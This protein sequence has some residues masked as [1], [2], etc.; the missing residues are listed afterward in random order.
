[1]AA[2]TTA[3]EEETRPE[4]TPEP[5]APDRVRSIGARLL[6][7]FDRLAT[8]SVLACAAPILMAAIL[9]WTNRWV[10]D[11]GWINMRVVEQFLAGNGPVYN[12]GER[13][14]V[15][16]STLWFWILLAGALV[17]PW[18]EAQITGA[19]AG[20]LLTLG[21]LIFASF[22]A[23][24]LFK[25]RKP[26]IYVPVGTLAMAA[27]PPFWDFTTSGLETG[28]SFGWLGCCFWMLARR[29]VAYEQGIRR[30]AWWPVFPALVIGLGPLVRPDFALYSGLFAIA[31]LMSSRFRWWDWPMC[32]V[33]ALAVPAGYQI[34]RMGFYASMVPNTA[35]AKD[36]T[37]SH[38][39]QGL[40]YLIDYAG[41]YV[42]VVPLL[43]VALGVGLHVRT[44]WCLR[45]W[46][47]WAVVGAPVLG[48]LLHAL[49]VVRIGGDFMHARF[50]LPD[51]F[52]MMMPV[53]VVG[54]TVFR[55]QVALVVTAFVAG[56]A[57]AIAPSMRTA[58][59]ENP[60]EDG[61][62]N[63]RAFYA[64]RTTT[65]KLLTEHDWMATLQGQR[66]LHARWD[67]E[68]GWGYY[69]EG[70]FRTPSHDGRLYVATHNLGIL[71]IAAGT[72]V[73]VIDQLALSDG[74]T[75]RSVLDPRLHDPDR[76]G[77]SERPASWR[78]ARYTPVGPKEPLPLTHAR[79]AMQCGD[80]KVLSDAITG[81]LTEDK[82]WENVRLAPRLTGFTFPADPAAARKQL[83]GWD[84][85]W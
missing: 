29:V 40:L 79:A 85:G 84:P 21:G 53:A 1:M 58:Y 19:V 20:W 30:P 59:D 17:L 56:W 47:R 71:S 9:G 48:G 36:A 6:H 34:W 22:G 50:L 46:A 35:L 75:S 63:E 16:T 83:C 4:A 81:E 2:M 61:I 54:I 13:V 12:I 49:Y 45:S 32:L 31:L 51:T 78:F 33:I 68:T 52:A 60:S 18:V 14:E 72:D 65:G 28:L 7:G 24:A 27:L 8:P 62:A 74:I 82:F 41:L 67:S 66:G 37:Q 43:A 69:D 70:G 73:M 10:A 25:A 11:D 38:W 57:V 64:E 26:I 39:E 15:T 23:A 44:A 3:L 42:L 76:I 77:H 5:P 55:K 80:L